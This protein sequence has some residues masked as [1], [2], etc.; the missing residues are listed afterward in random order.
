M[1]AQDILICIVGIIFAIYLGVQFYSGTYECEY[2]GFFNEA[3]SEA[4]SKLICRLLGHK[5]AGIFLFSVATYLTYIIFIKPNN[6]Q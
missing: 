3:G 1:K 2:S 5:V 6:D 4:I